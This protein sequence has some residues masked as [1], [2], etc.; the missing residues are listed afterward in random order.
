MNRRDLIVEVI[1]QHNTVVTQDS[2]D[3]KVITVYVKGN[4]GDKGDQ[5][6]PGIGA[7]LLE[8]NETTPPADTSYGTIIYRK[9]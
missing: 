9:G 5:G 4:K 8:A 2:L 3:P 7:L 1:K 6:A